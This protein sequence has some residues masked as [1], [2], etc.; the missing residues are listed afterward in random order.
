MNQKAV[1]LRFLSNERDQSLHIAETKPAGF[2]DISQIAEPSPNSASGILEFSTNIFEFRLGLYKKT[3][4]KA[5]K[6]LL[7]TLQN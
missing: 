1:L 3:R 6:Y 5:F 7:Y 4:Y 2:W